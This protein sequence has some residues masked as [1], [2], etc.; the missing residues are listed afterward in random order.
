MT[1]F[2]SVMCAAAG[3]LVL[4]LAACGGSSHPAAGP[5]PSRAAPVSASAQLT[6]AQASSIFTAFLP[7]FEQLASDPSP[8]S[9][10]TAG[11]ETATETFLAGRA[12]PA[13]GA[14]TG[15][16]FL[17]PTLTGYPRWFLA[18]GAASSQ[19]GFLFVMVQQSA[20]APWREAAEVYDLNSPG[21]ILPDLSSAGFTGSS[22]AGPVATGDSSLS[23]EPSALSAAYAH[24]LDDGARGESFVPGTYTIGYVE[25]DRQ[26]AAGAA[27]KGWRYADRQSAS[28]LP[29]YGLAMTGGDG[30]MVLFY[31]RDTTSWTATSAAAVIPSSSSTSL[32]TPPAE[33]LSRLGITA[34]R[35][36]L[37][38]T[39][40]S[41]DENLAFVGPTGARGVVIVVNVGRVFKLDKS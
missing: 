17:V 30:A 31:T 28:S 23:T 32:D 22:V 41:Y 5:T 4:S 26:F 11:P 14:L 27:A 39:A 9:Q 24:Y 13:P 20:G 1:A 18:V 3:A 8:M 37:R 35:P 29:V 40:F 16:R 19:R 7:K 2:H 33:F 6:V 10:L 34:A 38:V 36:G 25:S 12:G 15:E 21:Q